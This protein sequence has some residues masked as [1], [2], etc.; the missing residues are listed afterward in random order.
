MR[1]NVL[2]LAT[3]LFSVPAFAVASEPS[4]LRLKGL[5]FGD[6]EALNSKVLLISNEEMVVISPLGGF[7]SRCVFR[8]GNG[9][10]G[11]VDIVRFDGKSQLGLYRYDGG[12]LYLK[13]ADPKEPR[14]TESDITFPDGTP[15][16]HAV[17]ARQPTEDGLSVLSKYL[18]SKT[19]TTRLLPVKD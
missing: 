2:F 3:C 4:D 17:F 12:K 16:W 6:V 18:S 7:A 15:H 9:P 1:L 8:P 13:L 19:A 14:P 5:W 10:V 11:Q